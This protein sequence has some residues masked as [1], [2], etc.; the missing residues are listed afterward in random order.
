M[1]MVAPG[2]VAAGSRCDQPVN[3]MDV[4]PTALELAGVPVPPYLAGR[5]LLGPAR[6]EGSPPREMVGE[7]LVSQDD[8]RSLEYGDW[9]LIWF[10]G[11]GVCEL[12]SVPD[13]P[14]ERQPLAMPF[15]TDGYRRRL[16]A[17]EKDTAAL[18]GELGLPASRRSEAAA[19]A[20]RA[21]GYVK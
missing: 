4:M 9:K 16:E 21:L 5:S 1:A 15:V 3:L 18:R 19:G 12:Y 14:L 8:T 6:G 17:W 13:D 11:R 20:V 10:R 2:T 7:A